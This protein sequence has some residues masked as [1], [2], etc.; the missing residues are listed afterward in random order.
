ML[1]NLDIFLKMA[2]GEQQERAAGQG[3]LFGSTTA[4]ELKLVELPE[5]SEAELLWNERK[6]LGTFL[7]GHPITAY[8]SKYE[9]KITHRMRDVFD[10]PYGDWPT[11]QPVVLAGLIEKVYVNRTNISVRLSDETGSA[12][13]AFYRDD[14]ERAKWVLRKDFI[15]ALKCTVSKDGQWAGVKGKMAHKIAEFMAPVAG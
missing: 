11:M 10:L 9:R 4:D 7:S 14:A 13:I 1:A 5:F 8:R 2:K 12:E 6:V 15:I 3:D